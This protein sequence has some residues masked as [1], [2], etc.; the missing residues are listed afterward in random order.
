MSAT[1]NTDLHGDDESPLFPLWLRLS[2]AW[3]SYFSECGD[4]TGRDRV[5]EIDDFPIQSVWD[6]LTHP[7]NKVALE[8]ELRQNLN[9][10]ARA[11][12]EAALSRCRARRAP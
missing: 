6:E 1:E 12:R 2:E 4:L 8:D 11:A 5:W 10:V 3:L 7:T 9:P